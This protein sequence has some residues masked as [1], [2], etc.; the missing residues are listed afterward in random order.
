M[1]TADHSCCGDEACSVP[2]ELFAPASGRNRPAKRALGASES[3]ESSAQPHRKPRLR[4]GGKRPQSQYM[5]FRAALASVYPSLKGEEFKGQLQAALQW[6]QHDKGEVA[7]ANGHTDTDLWERTWRDAAEAAAAD[8]VRKED[9][10]ARSEAMAQTIR[11]KL[12]ALAAAREDRA[13]ALAAHGALA[14]AV[15]ACDRTLALSPQRGGVSLNELKTRGV[16]APIR[17]LAADFANQLEAARAELREH[18]RKAHQL[19]AASAGESCFSLVLLQEEPP[20]ADDAD[21]RL[22]QDEL[23]ASLCDTAEVVALMDA[24][25]T[26][27]ERCLGRDACMQA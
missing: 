20:A 13:D 22:E 26:R 24:L 2:A 25:D 6:L 21:W 8:D 11:A 15:D 19:D 12:A 18:S 14:S 9:L 7:Q 23:H 1:I 17:T 10:R 5:H 3:S 16:R 27:R 4:G